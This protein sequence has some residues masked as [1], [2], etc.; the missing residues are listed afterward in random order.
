MAKGYIIDVSK[1]LGSID[2]LQK[3]ILRDIDDELDANAEE[4]AGN[5]RADVPKS[6]AGSG[7]LAGSIS[8]VR[9][10]FLTRIVVAEKYYAPF[11][12]FGTGPYA[13]AY[14]GTLPA[15]IQEYAMQFYISGLGHMPP[16]PFIFPNVL[17]QIP[18]LTKRI[19]NAVNDQ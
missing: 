11:V 12:E 9:E 10:K 16:T 19:V 4:I 3:N 7:G 2:K 17:K 14:V 8:V 13:A 6:L 18:V 1:T 5:A 15:D